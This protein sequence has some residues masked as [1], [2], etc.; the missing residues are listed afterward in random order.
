MGWAGFNL[1]AAEQRGCVTLDGLGM[2]VNQGVAGI[3]LWTGVRVDPAPMRRELERLLGS[4]DG[5][6]Q[7]M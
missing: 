2:C 7:P 3:E 1:E 6:Q 4:S 5:G